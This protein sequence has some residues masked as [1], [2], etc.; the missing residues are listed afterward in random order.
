MPAQLAEEWL[1]FEATIGARPL[2]PGNTVA[3]IRANSAK[4]AAG[5]PPDQNSS[6]ALNIRDDVV[7]DRSVPIRTY[8]P[9]QGVDMLPVGIFMRMS[10]C[11][12]F[13]TRSLTCYETAEAALARHIAES[14]PMVVVS[15][16]YKLAPEH[17]WP[18][19]LHDCVDVAKWAQS[20]FAELGADVSR[21]LILTGVSS[22]AQLSISTAAQLLSESVPV[23]GVAPFVPLTLSPAA[24]TQELKASG[25]YKS[26]DEN[27]DGP[28]VSPKL[29]EVFLEAL[30]ADAN[31]ASFSVLFNANL[32]KFPPTYVVTC[33]ADILRDDGRLL[34]EELKKKGVTVKHDEYPGYPHVFWMI[35]GLKILERFYPNV[36]A[37][38]RAIL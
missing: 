20:K 23:R 19:S 29:L 10:P 13:Q 16:D 37:G 4:L 26:Y 3:E 17:K 8:I 34:V 7:G 14:V 9:K 38:F 33:G 6:P 21:G 2:P 18:A 27:G 12:Y 1:Q 15:V 31:D 28:L 25:K 5:P 35:P 30:G 22:G 11:S 32:N 36:T 24:V